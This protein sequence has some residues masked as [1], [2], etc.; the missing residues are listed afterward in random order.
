MTLRHYW[1]PDSGGHFDMTDYSGFGVQ[2]RAAAIEGL[3]NPKQ[4][5]FTR[6]PALLDGQTYSGWRAKPREVF[7]P[8]LINADDATWQTLQAAWWETLHPGATG[9]WEVYNTGTGLSRYLRVRF[10]E[11]QDGA[12]VV[13]PSV[14]GIELHGLVLVADDPWWTSEPVSQT[15]QSPADVLPFYSSEADRVFNLMPGNT[16]ATAEITNPG[17]VPAWPVYRFDGPISGFDISGQPNLHI[18]GDIEVPEDEW[19]IINTDPRVQT[20]S[21][22]HSA[23]TSEDVTDQLE[24][25]A[26]AAIP[27]GTTTETDIQINGS[28]SMT[29][30]I[31]PRYFRA[32]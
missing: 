26:F 2:L 3:G 23:W 17:Q 10:V 31:V 16:V 4:A 27:K 30:T 14:E 11:E 25:A 6:Q 19:L 1:L 20:A 21:L 5:E 7:W 32:F 9:T 15:F 24:R 28:G 12:Y 8:V 18:A 13:D 29:I 22:F